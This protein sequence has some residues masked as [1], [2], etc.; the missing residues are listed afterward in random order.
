MAI[1]KYI[2]IGLGWLWYIYLNVISYTNVGYQGPLHQKIIYSLISGVLLLFLNLAILKPEQL[3]KKPFDD[4][5]LYTKI[6]L[7]LGIV[8]VPVISLYYRA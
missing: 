5:S 4:L 3:L 8:I 1:I 7:L 2:Y 6:M